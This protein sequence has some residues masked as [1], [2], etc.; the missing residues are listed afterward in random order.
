[1]LLNWQEALSG[2][3]RMQENFVPDP[4]GADYF[5][6][7]DCVASR[8]RDLDLSKPQPAVSLSVTDAGSCCFWQFKHCLYVVLTNDRS[9]N[10]QNITPYSTLS[11]GL[12]AALWRHVSTTSRI[13]GDNDRCAVLKIAETAAAATAA[14]DALIDSFPF[15][16][17]MNRP[18]I[19]YH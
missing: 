10:N 13:S 7:P 11:A 8:V 6:T 4:A 15:S 9:V 5:V 3:H 18:V 12:K 19:T 16:S 2:V 14:A 1:V 17:T